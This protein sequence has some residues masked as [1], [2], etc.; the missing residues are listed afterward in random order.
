VTNPNDGGEEQWQEFIGG[1]STPVP[2]IL[3]G[4]GEL[5]RDYGVTSQPTMVFVAADGS[6]E[7]HAG[8]LGPQ[9]LLERLNQL[10]S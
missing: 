9:R 1:M 6:I 8:A 5:W 7:R 10:K 3:E 4:A 2:H